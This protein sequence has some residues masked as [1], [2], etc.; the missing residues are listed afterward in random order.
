M[1][2]D[3]AANELI[4]AN[5]QALIDQ[6]G[7]CILLGWSTSS[8]NVMDAVNTPERASKVKALI[9]IEGFGPEGR[10]GNVDLNK[11]IPMI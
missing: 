4:A 1:Y 10:I 11:H 2:R 7:P 8:Q 6:I 9:G 3:T 5:L